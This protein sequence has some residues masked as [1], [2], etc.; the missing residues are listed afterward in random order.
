MPGIFSVEFRLHIPLTVNFTFVDAEY[1]CFSINILEFV[2]GCNYLEIF[3][4]I[5]LAVKIC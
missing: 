2:L 1:L 3:I 5:D 4:F